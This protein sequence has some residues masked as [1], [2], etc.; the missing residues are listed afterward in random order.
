MTIAP[1]YAEQWQE[2][3]IRNRVALFVLLLGLPIA[4]LVAV[5]ADTIFPSVGEF[6]LLFSVLIWVSIIMLLCFRITRFQCPKCKQLFFS[7]QGERMFT[8]RRKC[9]SCGLNIYAEN[10]A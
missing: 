7:H 3:R 9:A 10:D 1:K 5:A 8:H 2:L 6:S 4:T